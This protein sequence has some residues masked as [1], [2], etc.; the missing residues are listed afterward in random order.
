MSA[1]DPKQSFNDLVGL[2]RADRS[3]RVRS[4]GWFPFPSTTSCSCGAYQ[5]RR[6]LSDTEVPLVACEGRCALFQYFVERCY[7]A[8]DVVAEILDSA[9]PPLVFAVI[10]PTAD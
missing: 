7:V 4:T 9:A 6:P 3:K 2:R 10:E 5:F 8:R 1:S